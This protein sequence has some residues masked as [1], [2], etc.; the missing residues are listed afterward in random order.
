MGSGCL[1]S[2]SKASSCFTKLSD[3]CVMYTGDPMT[4]GGVDICT[5]DTMAEVTA[6]ILQNLLDLADSSGITVPDIVSNCSYVTG[7]LAN[8]DINLTTRLQVLYDAACDFNARITALEN[9]VDPPITLD[10]PCLTLPESPTLNQVLQAIVTNGCQNKEDITNIYNQLADDTT[11]NSILNAVVEII[12]NKLLSQITSCQNN[13][14]KTGTGST[15][16][17]QFIGQIPIGGTT[18]GSFNI[19]AFDNTGLGLASSGMCGW[20]IC[21]GQNGTIDLRGFTVAGSNSPSIPGGAL[22]AMVQPGLDTDLQ[23]NIGARKGAYKVVLSASQIPNHFHVV[24][25]NPHIHQYQGFDTTA[26]SSTVYPEDGVDQGGSIKFAKPT[27]TTQSANADI[28]VG[29][30][31]GGSGVAHENRQ[32]TYYGIW[33]QRIS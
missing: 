4:I 15:A 10:A 22:N 13:I 30:V 17:L 27:L 31:T 18:F 8:Q 20:A 26:G 7:I 23:N 32:P 14:V 29:G 2:S 3:E 12:G 33:I 24:T 11:E 21:N 16:A 28:T 1:K 19:A 6:V 9:E 25:Q 5:G